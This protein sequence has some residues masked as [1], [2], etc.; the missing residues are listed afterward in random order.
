MTASAIALILAVALAV[1]WYRIHG[2]GWRIRRLQRRIETL[3]RCRRPAKRDITAV[4]RK[5]YGYVTW[6]IENKKDLYTYQA[7]D[8]LKLAVGSGL[9]TPD[10][11]GPI[12]TAVA[13]AINQKQ[14]EVASHLLDAFKPLVRKTPASELPRLL[15]RLSIIASVAMKAQQNYLAAKAAEIV[16]TALERPGID[17]RAV[18]A[19]AMRIMKVL[20]I[21]ALRRRDEALFRELLTRLRLWVEDKKDADIGFEAAHAITAWTARVVKMGS[22]ELFDLINAFTAALVEAKIISGT[23]LELLLNDWIQ[24][25]GTESLNLDNCYS[26]ELLENVLNLG[27]KNDHLVITRQSVR[28]VAQVASMAA[29]RYGLRE[30]FTV[31]LPLLEAGRRLLWNELRF[32]S[33]KVVDEYRRQT[34]HM[35]VRETMAVIEMEARQRMTCHGGDVILELFRQWS[36]HPDAAGK[37]KSIKRYTQFMLLYWMQI[38]QRQAKRVSISGEYA[39]LLSMNEEERESLEQFLI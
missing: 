7:V 33:A 25:A 21:I 26:H 17:D 30:G 20:G 38:R 3:A 32:A 19:S 39:V 27:I 31:V 36:A 13:Q 11:S 18:L 34:L 4:F 8:L 29:V 1:Y 16:F 6:G 12:M 35:L 22:K 37:L 9:A 10:E 28:A 5:I 15:E 2:P 14:P 24:L 23:A